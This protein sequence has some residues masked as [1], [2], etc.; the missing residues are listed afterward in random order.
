MLLTTTQYDASKEEQLIETLL[1]QKVD[2]LLL[3]VADAESGRALAALANENMPYVLMY[4]HAPGHETVSVDD[5]KAARDAIRHLLQFGHR[6][7]AMLAGYLTASDRSAHRHLGYQDAMRE[8]GLQPM[9][10]AEVDFGARA[11]ET[12][13]QCWLHKIDDRPTA[14]FCSTDLLA[15]GVIKALRER[16]I[17]IPQDISII[18][19]DGLEYG[20]LIEPTLATI[21][22]PNGEI[23]RKAAERLL[24]QIDEDP[25]ER[26][27]LFLT[28]T[29][30]AGRSVS[31]PPISGSPA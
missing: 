19:F 30:L 25:D 28:H 12:Q 9:P 7:I 5:R 18:G 10:L 1:Q 15:L 24:K 21:S 4:N 8:A 23:G 27:S 14:I 3:T 20:Q 11:L 26:Q 22:Q 31:V 2:G 17:R 16:S 29:L 13:L 6:R